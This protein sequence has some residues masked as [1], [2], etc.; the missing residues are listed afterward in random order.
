MR[1][2]HQ[3]RLPVLVDAKVAGAHVGLGEH[4]TITVHL[5]GRQLCLGLARAQSG[6]LAQIAR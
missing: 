3:D 6:R 1:E 4:E 2:I 5:D